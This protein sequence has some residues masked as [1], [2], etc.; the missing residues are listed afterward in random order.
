MA[1]DST[2]SVPSSPSKEDTHTLGCN[3]MR[4]AGLDLTPQG[5]MEFRERQTIALEL[6]M[7]L[8]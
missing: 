5:D 6:I 8:A 3:S 1:I 2:V 4:N 7:N